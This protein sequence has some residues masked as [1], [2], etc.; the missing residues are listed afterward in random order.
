MLGRKFPGIVDVGL[1]GG[2]RDS[3]SR[4]EVTVD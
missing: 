1:L 2:H 4:K 3:G